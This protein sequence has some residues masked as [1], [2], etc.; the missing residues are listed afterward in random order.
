M[1]LAHLPP[2]AMQLVALWLLLLAALLADFDGGDGP[3]KRTFDR[4]EEAPSRC[5]LCGSPV[6]DVPCG[7]WDFWVV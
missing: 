3:A 1:S 5:L 7:C 4:A 6:G 2:A